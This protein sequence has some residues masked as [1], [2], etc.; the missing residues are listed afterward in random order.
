MPKPLKEYAINFTNGTRKIVYAHFATVDGSGSLKMGINAG[1][2][3][4]Y[5]VVV[6]PHQWMMVEEVEGK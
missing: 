5:P 2:Y 1:P 4:S 6:A 3:A